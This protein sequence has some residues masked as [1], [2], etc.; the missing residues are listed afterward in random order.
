MRSSYLAIATTLALVVAVSNGPA[1]AAKV[2]KDAPVTAKARSAAQV[3][4]AS[5]ETRAR[6][7]AIDNWSNR[8]RDTHGYLYSFWRRAEDQKVECGGGESAKHCTVSARPCRV[9]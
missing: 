2:C 4:D 5:R 7:N 9:Y 6:N 8:A 3:S 1:D